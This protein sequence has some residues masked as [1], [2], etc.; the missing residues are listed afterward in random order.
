MSEE[1]KTN[2]LFTPTSYKNVGKV[3]VDQNWKT[4]TEPGAYVISIT[5]NK[6]TK[7]HERRTDLQRVTG[8]LLE[9][10]SFN[11]D[12]NWE[13]MGVPELPLVGSL[14]GMAG[15]VSEMA[16]GG[17]LGALWK[18]KKLWKKSGYLKVSPKF[19]VIDE[20]G[21]GFP[22]KVARAM[23]QF[24]VADTDNNDKKAGNKLANEVKEKYTNQEQSQ[25]DVPSSAMSIIRGGIDA[26]FN[27]TFEDAD[28][29][30]TLQNSPTPV[31]LQLGQWFFH[32]LLLLQAILKCVLIFSL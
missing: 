16:G 23:S 28:S 8:V 22:L 7:A 10:V 25:P 2:S 19:R 13:A 24:C 31:M 21:T 12:S 32:L 5:P 17:E 6:I 14:L 3:G 18:S 1:F 27:N 9:P 26:A 20:N 11:I 4:K 30:L 15:G 29:L